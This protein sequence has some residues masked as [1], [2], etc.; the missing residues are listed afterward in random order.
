MQT[1]DQEKIDKKN[2]NIPEQMVGQRAIGYGDVFQISKHNNQ[3]SGIKSRC[4]FVK[5][6]LSFR[7]DPKNQSTAQSLYIR[8]NVIFAGVSQT[9]FS[10][11]KKKKTKQ[12]RVPTPVTHQ[13][14]LPGSAWHGGHRCRIWAAEGAYKREYAAMG[15]DVWFSCVASL[16]DI[17]S[18]ALC[19]R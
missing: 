18:N 12:R 11:V 4:Q 15:D 19:L 1:A 5:P 6:F 7:K 8:P 17:Q 13:N 14:P 3:S 2:S 16:W 10:G 9:Q